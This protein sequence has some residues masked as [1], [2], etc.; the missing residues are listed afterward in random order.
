MNTDAPKEDRTVEMV[1]CKACGKDVTPVV[2]MFATKL[3]P[4]CNIIISSDKGIERGN[5]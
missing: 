1:H 2:K 4:E 3:C 5:R